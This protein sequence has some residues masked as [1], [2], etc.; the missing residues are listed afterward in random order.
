ML[1]PAAMLGLALLALV[2]T[3]AMAPAASAHSTLLE[4][5]PPRDQ[6]VEHSPE[7]V[8]LHFDEPFRKEGPARC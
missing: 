2:A 6:V 1:R 5:E 4:T 7:R 8:A 3:L